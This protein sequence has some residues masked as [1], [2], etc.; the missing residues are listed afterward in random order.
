MLKRSLFRE[1]R[2]SLGR[3]LAIFAIIALGVGFFAGLSVSN[4][5]MIETADKYVT[6]YSLFDY[7]LVSTLGFE[8]ED[9]AA[10][11]RLDG[12]LKAEGSVFADVISLIKYGNTGVAQ[13]A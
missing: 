2:K 10:I 1:I 4:D 8:A 5:A 3:Y 6:E 9:V 11:S 7:R 13:S 12:V